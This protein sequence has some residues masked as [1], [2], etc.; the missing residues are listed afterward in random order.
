MSLAVER[1]LELLVCA[2]ERA[3]V[4]V[5]A[6]AAF[7]GADEQRHED[8]AVERAGLIGRVA[9]M[10]TR[11][12]SGGRLALQIGNRLTHVVSLEETVGVRLDEAAHKRAV[13]V[14]RRAAVRPVLLEREREVR[15]VERRER[16]EAEPAQRVME[17]R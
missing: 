5:E 14:E 4:P 10:R 13:L 8:T 2:V 6:A 15:A 9:L 3:V 11:E 17:K 12:D 1:F 16:A 7:R